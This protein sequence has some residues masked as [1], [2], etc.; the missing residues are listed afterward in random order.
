VKRW[1][2]ALAVA[3]PLA[4]QIKLPPYTREVLPNGTVVYLAPKPGLPLVNFR[5]LVKGGQEAEP[6]GLAGLASV[7][8]G[9][10]RRGAAQMTGDQFAE[11]LDGLGGTFGAN[12]DREA[13]Q[14]QAEF[15]QKDFDRGLGLV[16]DAV[17]R[18]T[19]P[20]AEVRK[21]LARSAD[22]LKS[23]KDN[24]G[25][26][27]GNF[28]ESVFFGAAHPYGRVPDEASID[29]IRRDDILAFHKR[30]FTGK[31][32]VVI[33][34]GDFDA[35]V[36]KRRVAEMFGAAPAGVAFEWT[37]DQPPAASARV[38]LIDKPDATQTYFLIAQPG[39]RRTSPDRTALLLVN[40][41]FGGRFTS[42]INEELRINTG[43]TYGARCQ[44]DQTRLTGGLYISS[45]TRTESTERALDLSLEVLKRLRTQGLSAEQL[46]SAKAYT[47]GTYPPRTVQTSD[48][49][50]NVLGDME[51]FGLGRDE[52][53][54]FFARVDGVTLEQANA[55]IQ[56]YYRTD[57]L[58]FVLLGNASKIRTVAAKYGPK[59]TERPA[60]AAGWKA[61]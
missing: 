28:Y 43:L 32:L 59:V 54:G 21:A 60:R 38:L 8:A 56:K 58:T 26:A 7:T 44:V 30:M 4:A 10:L 27:I 16:A 48:Q 9:L 47:K 23:M 41:I 1:M 2:I 6:A 19:F 46:A 40:T 61:E 45:Y 42:M 53:D 37:S 11:A 36:A 20:D 12:S 29:R 15:L 17:L 50:A 55:A 25:A 51:L 3:A 49:I 39:A 35:A 31:N 13:V 14:I 52:V 57:N 33:V 24:P 22:G 5:I 18:P 34:A